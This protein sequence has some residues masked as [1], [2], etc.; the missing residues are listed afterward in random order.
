MMRTR[1]IAAALAIL[2]LGGLSGCATTD[3]TAANGQSI[4]ERHQHNRDAKQGAAASTS[5]AQ[6][7]AQKPLHDH[8]ETK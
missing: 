8:R 3:D 1:T 2:G 7:P 5:A 4:A 6:Q